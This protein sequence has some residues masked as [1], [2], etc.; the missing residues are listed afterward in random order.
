MFVSGGRVGCRGNA[1][2]ADHAALS[3]GHGRIQ[4]LCGCAG[5]PC[6]QSPAAEVEGESVRVGDVPYGVIPALDGDGTEDGSQQSG[7]VFSVEAQWLPPAGRT[8]AS[9]G[10]L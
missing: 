2:P 7:T 8:D 1:D 3:D 6:R 5:V 10:S 4:L 9:S